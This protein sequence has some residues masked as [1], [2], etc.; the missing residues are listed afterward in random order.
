MAEFQ[1][2]SKRFNPALDPTTAEEAAAWEAARRPAAPYK[3]GNWVKDLID[4][5]LQQYVPQ[6]GAPE[7]ENVQRQLNF[8][9]A[10]GPG[11]SSA[12]G[13]LNMFIGGWGIDKMG[14]GKEAREFLRAHRKIQDIVERNPSVADQSKVAELILKKKNLWREHRVG[15]GPEMEVLAELPNDLRY[16]GVRVE[17]P[18]VGAKFNLPSKDLVAARLGDVL[19]H[20]DLG[21]HFPWYKDVALDYVHIPPEYYT[22]GVGG[23]QHG[24]PLVGVQ[25]SNPR[26]AESVLLH[27]LQHVLQHVF[28][29]PRGRG[30][31]RGYWNTAGEVEAR[32]VQSRFMRPALYEHP[33]IAT[34]DVRRADM[35][36]LY[37]DP[38]VYKEEV[39]PWVLRATGG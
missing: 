21:K 2:L 18:D 24:Y 12:P 28:N 30:T 6:P 16:P 13:R 23:F 15:S 37:T 32:N 4:I 5:L 29:T 25:A 8:A 3:P 10:A 27:E 14:L 9:L 34:E 7:E 39:L 31:G 38:R 11:G 19:E 20:K 17:I 36:F 26:D 22:T 35:N 1:R 33:P